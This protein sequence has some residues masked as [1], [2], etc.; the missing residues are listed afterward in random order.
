[1]VKRTLIKRERP[2]QRRDHLGAARMAREPVYRP[3]ENLL[4]LQRRK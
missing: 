3:T 2:F 1:M 4:M